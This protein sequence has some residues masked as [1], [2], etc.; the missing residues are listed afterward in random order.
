MSALR[1][2]FT[3][4]N[5][6]LPSSVSR[7]CSVSHGQD[8]VQRRA[9]RNDTATQLTLCED[10]GLQFRGATSPL[11][12]ALRI[13]PRGQWGA[14]APCGQDAPRAMRRLLELACWSPGIGAGSARRYAIVQS[15]AAITASATHPRP[16]GASLTSPESDAA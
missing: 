6:T 7:S 3:P 13:A 4:R 10:S 11:C 14:G 5:R 1:S 8:T 2:P 9:G 12:G 16:D 15:Y